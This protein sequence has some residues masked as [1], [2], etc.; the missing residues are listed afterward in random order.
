M[1]NYKLNELNLQQGNIKPQEITP[2]GTHKQLQKSNQSQED[3]REGLGESV[4]V[5]MLT[6]AM[7]DKIAILRG[8]IVAKILSNLSV[9]VI[10]V[11]Q[12]T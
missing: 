5:A 7:V 8:S 1:K 11:L 2:R 9:I 4:A 3:L 12:E 6:G 10:S